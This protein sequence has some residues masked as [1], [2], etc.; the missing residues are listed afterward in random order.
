MMSWRP[1]FK[2]TSTVWVL[3]STGIV[4]FYCDVAWMST[5]SNLDNGVNGV[6]ASRLNLAIARRRH[7]S[8]A[9]VLTAIMVSG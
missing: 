2:A 3:N 4:G 9:L 8:M 5:P 7:A 6:N 1:M